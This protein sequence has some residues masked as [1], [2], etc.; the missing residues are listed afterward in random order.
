VVKLKARTR[1]E[2]AKMIARAIPYIGKETTG[3]VEDDADAVG[4]AIAALV[5]GLGHKS[6][7]T[8]VCGLDEFK[9][10]SLTLEIVQCATGRG[11]VD[12]LARFGEGSGASRF[13]KWY[14]LNFSD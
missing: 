14:V 2:E 6:T 8:Q 13:S 1:K 7:L 4:D 3:S 11:G 9:T 5:E 10:P 12:C